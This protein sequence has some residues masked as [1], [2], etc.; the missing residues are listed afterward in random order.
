MLMPARCMI[1]A[2]GLVVGLLTATSPEP[3]AGVVG[4]APDADHAHTD[5]AM[6][7]PPA[8]AYVKRSVLLPRT[9]WTVTA[10]D[11]ST[12]FPAGNVIDG[13][14][15]TIWHSQYTGTPVALPHTLTIDM[16]ATRTLSGLTYL[17]RQD[18]SSNGNIGRYSI[19]VSSDAIAWGMPVATGTW[20]DDKIEKHAVFRAVNARYLRLTMLTE[21]GNRGPWSAAAEI[22][23]KGGVIAPP[24]L[25]RSGW[26]VA[27]SDQSSVFPATHVL[28]GNATTIWH[29]SYVGPSGRRCHT[30]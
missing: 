16:H 2:A 18:A 24:A 4:W 17:S 26:T 28:D 7:G 12:N 27:A 9:G 20:S 6:I 15:G 25:P 21:A 8:E 10:S 19:S 13:N 1:L 3:A 30:V 11:Q 23:L 5:E 22:N 29:S 14:A